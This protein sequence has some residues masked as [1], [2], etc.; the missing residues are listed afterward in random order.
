MLRISSLFVNSMLVFTALSIV[1]CSEYVAPPPVAA[2]PPNIDPTV[3]SVAAKTVEVEPAMS[4]EY[5][6]L[7]DFEKHVILQKGTEVAFT[8]EYTDLADA[9]TF[10]CR[11]CNAPLYNSNHKFKS[12][13]GWPSFDDEI[14]GAVDRHTDADGHRVEITC[15]NCQGHLGHVFEGEGYTDKN[16]RH[17]VNSV[18]MRF[19]PEGMDLPAMAKAK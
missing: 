6:E 11:Q 9:G 8:G 4:A 14:A 19:V 13:C 16:I 17:C 5:N 10:I 3:N 1:G 12:H 7:N 2:T 18:S 15:K